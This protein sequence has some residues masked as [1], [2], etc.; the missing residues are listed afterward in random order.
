[1]F[2]YKISAYLQ[3]V[4][5]I[6]FN[7]WQKF[8]QISGTMVGK[9]I[10]EDISIAGPV[11]LGRS[12]QHPE[13]PGQLVRLV[14]ARKQRFSADQLCQDAATGPNIYRGCVGGSQ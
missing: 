13:D 1:M 2:H 12:T 9:V 14:E 4:H 11:S 8:Q 5:S 7:L 6:R 3:Q 10:S